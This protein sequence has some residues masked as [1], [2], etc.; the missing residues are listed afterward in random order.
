MNKIAEIISEDGEVLSCAEC[1]SENEFEFKILNSL[2]FKNVQSFFKK[3]TIITEIKRKHTESG[4]H[5]G[6]T[7]IELT[8]LFKWDDINACVAEL[9]EKKIIKKK[10]GVSL[11]MYFMNKK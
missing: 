1:N 2:D 11:E 7:P 5:N 3:K 8:N 4:G 9:E 6:V 10:Q